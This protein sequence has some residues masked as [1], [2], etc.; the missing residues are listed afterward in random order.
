MSRFHVV[1]PARFA[2]TRFPGKPLAV[3][4][5]LPMIAHVIARAA[6]SGALE[7]IVA[8]DDERIA[9]VA[10]VHGATIAM[11]DPAHV[12]GTDRVAEVARQRAWPTDAVVVN[13][14]G[15]SPLMPPINVAQAAA[16][17]WDHPLAA[18]GTLCVPIASDADRLNPNVVKVVADRAGR[19]LYFSRAAIPATAHGAE[20]GA[21]W[22]HLGLYAYRVGSLAAMSAAAPCA[23]EQ[24]E[25]LEQLRALWMG[26]EIRVQPAQATPGPDV[27]TPADVPEVER[28][29]ARQLATAGPRS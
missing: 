14:Q 8:T 7:V 28:E 15:D 6:A 11:T 25:K 1:I 18:I 24:S 23:I 26:L 9:G 13:L 27:D 19:A 16:L 29:L 4:A 10:R 17:L 2:S 5:G 22:R 12:S 20:P 21:A 3:M